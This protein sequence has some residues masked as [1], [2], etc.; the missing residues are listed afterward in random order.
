MHGLGLQIVMNSTSR[1]RWLSTVSKS[2]S[3]SRI[4]QGNSLLL[5]A[6]LARLEM[7][8]GLDGTDKTI[9][10]YEIV[11][12]IC[13]RSIS[14]EWFLRFEKFNRRRKVKFLRSFICFQQTNK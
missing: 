6:P 8:V 2:K 1:G 14:R 10:E 9:W 4:W 5:G 3:S 7:N 11:Q 13:V 12:R